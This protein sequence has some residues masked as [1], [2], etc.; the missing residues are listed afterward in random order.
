[1]IIVTFLVPRKT[2]GHM[3]GA[4]IHFC[5]HHH[6][7]QTKL[8]TTQHVLVC[9]VTAALWLWSGFGCVVFTNVQLRSGCNRPTD[10]QSVRT[11]D[12]DQLVSRNQRRP[13]LAILSAWFQIHQPGETSSLDSLVQ[14]VCDEHSEQQC[15]HKENRRSHIWNSGM[16]KGSRDD[17][18]TQWWELQIWRFRFAVTLIYGYP[19]MVFILCL[20]M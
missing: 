9:C 6:S 11:E 17:T 10:P 13:S 19:Y 4:V 20:Y 7:T 12:V 14:T 16:K 3:R 1:M 15:V 8:A 5:E 2:S 18:Q